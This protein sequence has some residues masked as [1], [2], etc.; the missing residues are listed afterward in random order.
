MISIHFSFFLVYESIEEVI[1]I[2]LIQIYFP[3]IYAVL[4]HFRSFS[5]KKTELAVGMVGKMKPLQIVQVSKSVH[6]NEDSHIMKDIF[7][8]LFGFVHCMKCLVPNRAYKQN[9][10][11]IPTSKVPFIL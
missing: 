11:F 3:N 6:D 5:D 7:L 10:S 8:I 9:I 4:A 1:L 2:F